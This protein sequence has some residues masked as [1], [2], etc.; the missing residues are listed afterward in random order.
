LLD[1]EKLIALA[2]KWGIGP[3]SGVNF[4][5][6]IERATREAAIEECIEKLRHLPNEECISLDEAIRALREDR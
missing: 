1:E 4:A 5:R 6:A 3:T 2:A